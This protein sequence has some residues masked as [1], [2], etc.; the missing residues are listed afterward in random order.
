MDAAD[1][2]DGLGEGL[3]LDGGGLDNADDDGDGVDDAEP[4]GLG[5]AEL[6]PDGL[7]D[8]DDVAA[9]LFGDAEALT[10]ATRVGDAV[11]RA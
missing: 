11:L 3:E 8:G 2:G 4:R 1:G 6:A 9:V 10:A 7:A 5:D